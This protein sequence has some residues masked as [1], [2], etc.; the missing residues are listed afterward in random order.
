MLLM[1]VPVGKPRP[2]EAEVGDSVGEQRVVV[3][4]VQLGKLSL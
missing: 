3:V 4:V 1:Q 2:L